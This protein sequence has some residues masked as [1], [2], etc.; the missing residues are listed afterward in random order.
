MP[1]DGLPFF[2][3]LCPVEAIAYPTQQPEYLTQLQPGTY[4]AVLE[5]ATDIL[6]VGRLDEV[7]EIYRLFLG[8]PADWSRFLFTDAPDYAPVILPR[9]TG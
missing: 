3:V 5:Q 7:P 2:T 9:R 4:Y 6:A 1:F 8:T